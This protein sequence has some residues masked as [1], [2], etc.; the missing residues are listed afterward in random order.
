MTGWATWGL[1]LAW[2]LHDIEEL[3]T[4]PGWCGRNVA[5]FTRLYNHYTDIYRK[6]L[7]RLFADEEFKRATAGQSSR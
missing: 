2:L 5:R 6:L 1:F 4:M 3:L 7:Q